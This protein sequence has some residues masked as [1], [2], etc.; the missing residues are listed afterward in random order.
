MCEK[1]KLLVTCNFS[2]SPSVFKS[3]VLHTRDN[4]GLFGK[5]LKR[6]IDC[7]VFNAVFNSITIVLGWPVH[8]SMLSWS[9][10]NQYSA[11]YSFQATGCFPI[12]PML[13][14]RTALTD[15]DTDILLT[16]TEYIVIATF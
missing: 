5:G 2:F 11:Q 8:L 16:S 4:Q 12:Q 10:F 14:Q 7:M 6:L 1:E 3:L 15:T 13:K 9:S